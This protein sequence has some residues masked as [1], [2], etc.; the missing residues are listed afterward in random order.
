[1]RAKVWLILLGILVLFVAV[2]VVAL[3]FG[4]PKA[5]APASSELLASPPTSQSGQ[6]GAPT[7][8]FHGPTGAPYVKGPTAP[9]SQ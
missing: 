9:P 7:S 4:S 3:F 6:R 5:E 8:T 2:Y 1:M